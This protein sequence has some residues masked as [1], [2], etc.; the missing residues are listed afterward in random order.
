[1]PLVVT[2]KLLKYGLRRILLLSLVTA[3]AISSCTIPRKYQQN[4]PF[5]FKNNIELKGGSF[6]KDERLSLK[7]RLY[8]QLDDSVKTKVKDW[9]FFLHIIK[10]PPAYDSTYAG[11]SSRNIRGSMIHLGY[12]NARVAFRADTAR[13][14]NQQRVTINYTVEAGNP[15]LIDTISYR[16]KKKELQDLAIATKPQSFLKKQ[17]PVTKVNVLSEIGRLVDLYRNNGYYKFSSDD[18]RM[19]GDTTIEALTK[20]TDDPFSNLELLTNANQKK[21][22][23]TIKLAMVLN[24]LTDTAKLIKYTISNIYLYPDYTGTEDD[25]SKKFSDS[26]RVTRSGYTIRFHKKLFRTG[27]LTRNMAFRK[28][29]IYRQEDYQKTMANFSKSGAWQNVNIQVLDNK[30]SAGKVDLLVQ[31]IPAKKY[32]FEANIEASYS[33]NSSTNATIAAYTGNLLGISSNISLINRNLRKEGIR[34]V[35]ALR[36]G[37]ELNLSSQRA[38]GNVIN[39]TE[40]SYSNS[41]SIPRLIMPNNWIKGKKL[42]SQQSF[43][44]S[45]VAYTKRISLFELQSVGFALGWDWTSIKHPNRSWV[46]KPLNFEFSYLYNQSDSFKKT[47]IDNPYLQYSFNTALVMG[48]SASY[49]STWVNPKHTNRLR[50]LKLTA[51]E[52][53][54]LFGMLPLGPMGLFKN[55]IRQ[56]A[57]IDIEYNYLVSHQKSAIAT[58]FFLGI[59]APIGKGDSS[60]PFFK[61]YFSG[62]ANSM[63]GWPVRGIGRGAQPLAPYGSTTLND[64]TGDIKI[65]GNLEYRYNIAQ[66]IPNSLALKGALFLDAGNIWNFRNS[67]G[68]RADS[69]QFVFK[70][71]YK[72]LGV[73]VGTGF[74]FDFNYFMVRF[75][76]GFRIK[77]PD[78]QAN[79]GWQFPNI[80]FKNL[81]GR[82]EKVPDLST[83]DPNDKVND[84]RYRKWRYENFNFTIGLSYPF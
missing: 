80:S 34:M 17:T 83:P 15:T 1:M 8:G 66:I 18:L 43:I 64:R 23:P 24:P 2:D 16:L 63:R 3:L 65:E 55:Y 26:E 61:Q 76:L 52:S 47:L 36:A 82:G 12:Y 62:G 79:D 7:Q 57:K 67:N 48:A 54:F 70:N 30:D 28:G 14:G 33:A 4:K 69:L 10:E 39:S 78:I 56:F 37:A 51:E 27:F 22:K 31:M 19:R 73:T 32:G 77:R 11:I 84:N 9:L 25:Y 21:D 29:D 44:N 40:L 53:G 81:F 72:Q 6:T 59:G 46:L 5:V 20:I 68:G 13:K 38:A 50:T 75:D 71:L 41:I 74:R 35:H 58:R 60:L 45:S 49:T 42:Q